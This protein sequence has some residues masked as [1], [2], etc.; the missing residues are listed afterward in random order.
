MQLLSSIPFAQLAGQSV[1]VLLG[2]SVARPREVYCLHLPQDMVQP[3]GLGLAT[4][5]PPGTAG[6]AAAI[7]AMMMSQR[8]GTAQTADWHHHY[9]RMTATG[10]CRAVMIHTS[11]LPAG[12]CG[13]QCIMLGRTAHT[14]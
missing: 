4:G 12:H 9:M 13:W 2:A 10:Q 1:V 8:A 6:P 11:G 7:N 3:G 14:A 5:G